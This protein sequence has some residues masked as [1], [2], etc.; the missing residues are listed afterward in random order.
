MKEEEREGGRRKERSKGRRRRKERR[1]GGREGGESGEG[2]KEGE[3]EAGRISCPKTHKAL[4]V[5]RKDSRNTVES[6]TSDFMRIPAGHPRGARSALQ[7]CTIC[8][9]PTWGH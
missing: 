2:G 1:E 7:L 4:G 3:R 5:R 6:I 8:A 9:S